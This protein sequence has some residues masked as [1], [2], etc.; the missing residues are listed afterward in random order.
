M[1]IYII[2]GIVCVVVFCW[3]LKVIFVFLL[4]G[5][6]KGLFLF[7]MILSY[8]VFLVCC[9]N[10]IVYGMMNFQFKLVFKVLF[11]KRGMRNFDFVVFFMYLILMIY[12]K[13]FYY[14]L[15]IIK[16]LFNFFKY[17]KILGSSWIMFLLF[18]FVLCYLFF[19]L[20]VRI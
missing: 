6:K 13:Q 19:I 2:L 11:I 18:V 9:L 8:F 14:G 17:F 20:D 1:C 3:F 5:G 7:L 16:I 10:F 12:L 15:C 4:G